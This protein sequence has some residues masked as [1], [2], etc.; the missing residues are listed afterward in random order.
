[1]LSRA[2][3]AVARQRHDLVIHRSDGFS[4]HRVRRQA[5]SDA[6]GRERHELDPERCRGHQWRGNGRVARGVP[7]RPRAIRL[8]LY[9]CALARKC[10]E[11]TPPE[12]ISGEPES[13]AT[14]FIEL[15]A[16]CT[17]EPW[18]IARCP[19]TTPCS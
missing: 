2:M 8:Q 13:S 3:A 7:P 4:F 14:A 10:P 17:K 12:S 5:V 19:T 1:M 15:L 9:L 6:K 16:V 11:G 18:R